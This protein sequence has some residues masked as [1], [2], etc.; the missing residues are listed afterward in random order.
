MDAVRGWFNTDHVTLAV[1]ILG[2]VVAT[3]G[4]VVAFVYGRH[5]T[6]VGRAA[7]QEAKRSADASEDSAKSARESADA[8]R[9][10]ADI[11]ARRDHRDGA[12]D[13]LKLTRVIRKMSPHGRGDARFAEFDNGVTR[14]F[15][16][17]G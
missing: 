7:Q 9:R 17:S 2:L 4:V 3:G 15:I 12:P 6:N 16:Y 8:A 13:G 11:E 5:Q 1:A 10:L 14:E